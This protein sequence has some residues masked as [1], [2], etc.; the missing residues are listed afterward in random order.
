MCLRSSLVV[1]WRTG[2]GDKEHSGAPVRL[3]SKSVLPD[4]EDWREERVRETGTSGMRQFLSPAG[5]QGVA[6]QLMTVET[7]AGSY[8]PAGS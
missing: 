5:W 6:S 4:S 2:D 8:R 1:V 7:S 3:S